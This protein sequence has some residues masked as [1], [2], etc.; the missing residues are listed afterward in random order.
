MSKASQRKLSKKQKVTPKST[1]SDQAPVPAST[2]NPTKIQPQARMPVRSMA[3]KPMRT[4][5][6]ARKR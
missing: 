5:R 6:A 3:N 1:V 2:S 4:Q